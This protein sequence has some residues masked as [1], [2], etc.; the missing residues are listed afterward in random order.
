LLGGFSPVVA[1]EKPATES[2][3]ISKTDDDAQEFRSL[4]DGKTLNGW[5]GNLDWFRVA[6]GAIVAGSQEKDIPQNEFLCTEKSYENFELKLK[7]KLVGKGDNAGI[8]FRSSRIPNHHE[9]IGFQCD[10][11]VMQDRLIWGSLYDESRRRTFLAHGEKEAVDKA[12]KKDDWNEFTIRCQG[13]RIQIWLNDLQTVDYTEKDETIETS[14]LIGLQ[15]HSG[16][17]AEAMYK[18]VRIRELKTDK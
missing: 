4:F 16:P 8:Q 18:D 12:F 11:G 10:I 6:E 7:A 2:S 14:G 15:I 3:A 9:M 1:Q 5:Q 13:N 17:A